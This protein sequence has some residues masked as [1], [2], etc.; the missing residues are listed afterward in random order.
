MVARQLEARGIDDD[1]VLEAMRRVPRERFLPERLQ[2]SA[3]DDGPLPIGEGQTISQPYMVGS[4]TEAL[5]LQG[6]E[7]V[8]EIGTGSGYQTAVLAELAHEVI[9]IERHQSLA[10]RARSILTEL[11]YENTRVQVADGT[12]GWPE[13]A[14]YS[15]IL[16]TAGAP[17]APLALLSQLDEAGRLVVPVGD[18]YSQVIETHSRNPQGTWNINRSTACRFVPLIGEQGWDN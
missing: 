3:F 7:R 5:G 16:V 12:L 6:T 9:S 14:P 17:K 18:R 15:A 8:L 2:A 1:R 4:M 10:E 11:G 13:S